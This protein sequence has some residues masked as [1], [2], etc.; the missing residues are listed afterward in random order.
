[1]H[2]LVKKSSQSRICIVHLFI[3]FVLLQGWCVA[4]ALLHWVEHYLPWSVFRHPSY[5]QSRRRMT[6]LTSFLHDNTEA[7]SLHVLS[8]RHSITIT[9][10]T[11]SPPLSE[12]FTKTTFPAGLE[13]LHPSRTSIP[14]THTPPFTAVRAARAPRPP[15]PHLCRRAAER[16]ATGLSSTA[17]EAQLRAAPTTSSVLRQDAP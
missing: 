11:Q 12:L 2:F 3:L 4:L 13:T 9:C 7:S 1:M 6:D 14:P 8:L 17:D 10:T 15:N 16:G 5:H